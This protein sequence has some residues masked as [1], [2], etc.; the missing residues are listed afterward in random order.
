MTGSATTV[1]ILGLSL[2]F[3]AT[4]PAKASE[5]QD[6]PSPP[7]RP[8]EPPF[9]KPL[10]EAPQQEATP[11]AHAS[12]LPNSAGTPTPAAEPGACL[13]RLTASGVRA[14]A[15]PAPTPTLADCGIAAPVTLY[16]IAL[17]SGETLDLPARP[18]LDC[19]FA[20]TFAGFV[21]GLVAP[22]AAGTLG[23]PVAALDTGP[24]YECRPRNHVAGAKT[25]AHGQ[26][27]AIDVM[28]VVLAG[29]QRISIA[30]QDD[31]RQ[32]LFVRT[33][34]TAA[35]GWFTTVLGPGSD[36]AHATHLH[37]DAQ[38]HGTSS[39]YRICE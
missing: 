17:A 34:R 28:G 35:C 19:A 33:L 38:R 13:A 39:N 8:S 23:S 30:R 10:R 29:Q 5:V 9:T 4:A 32:A 20:E 31:L 36:A 21:R 12:A 7:V 2:G 24:G 37:L 25:S 1:L 15:A 22:L 16:A 26:G 3:L 11:V 14:E 6:W 18:V 27:A